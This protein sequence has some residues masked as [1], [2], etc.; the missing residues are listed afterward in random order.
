MDVKNRKTVTT[1]KFLSQFLT[2]WHWFMGLVD[3]FAG[4]LTVK[5]HSGVFLGRI[6]FLVCYDKV[7]D[8][9]S[10]FLKF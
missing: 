7:A 1:T 8:V 10:R 3:I 2:F 6:P 5:C 9:C 4:S